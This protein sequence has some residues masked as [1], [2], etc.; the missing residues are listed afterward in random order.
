LA[1]FPRLQSYIE[2]MGG[3]GRAEGGEK[4]SERENILSALRAEMEPAEEVGA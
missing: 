3:R 4:E 1:L 2:R